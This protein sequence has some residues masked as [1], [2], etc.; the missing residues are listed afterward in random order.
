MDQKTCG[1]RVFARVMN[2]E[3]SW[4]H[5]IEENKMIEIGRKKDIVSNRYMTSVLAGFHFT[6]N[7]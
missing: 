5:V 3:E 7:C 2:D 1:Q 6:C 4:V